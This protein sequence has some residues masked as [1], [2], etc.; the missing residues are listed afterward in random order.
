MG[1]VMAALPKLRPTAIEVARVFPEYGI[2]V[3]SF[4]LALLGGVIITLMTWMERSTTSVPAKL[5]AASAAAFLLAAGALNHAI[6]VS[7]E[8]FAALHAG[9][10]LRYLDWLRVVAWASLGNMV[11]GIGL[12]TVLRLVQV[13]RRKLRERR[14]R[15]PI[16]TEPAAGPAMLRACWRGP[17]SLP[18]LRRPICSARTPFTATG[19]GFATWR[20]PRSPTSTTPAGP[21]SG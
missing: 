6:V 9:A 5:A 17:S 12:V 13:V 4:S 3:R 8:M 20:R 18:S 16:R 15:R 1:I 19:S 7:L 2:G 11:G 21:S 14:T 10:P